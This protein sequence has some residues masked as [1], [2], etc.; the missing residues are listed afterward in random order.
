MGV[1]VTVGVG[2]GVRVG[3]GV[4]VGVAVGLG[5]GVSVGV[6]SASVG[7]GL[8]AVGT[9]NPPEPPIAA[10]V[11]PVVP[12]TTTDGVG[13]RAPSPMLAGDATAGTSGWAEEATVAGGGVETAVVGCGPIGTPARK[14]PNANNN[15]ANPYPVNNRACN[16]SRVL[17]NRSRNN[18][19]GDCARYAN[20]IAI[21]APRVLNPMPHK[22]QIGNPPIPPNY[23]AKR[24]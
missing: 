4:P 14:K 8:A 10:P 9:T 3:V 11:L 21:R 6:P 17:Y 12:V 18:I 24:P 2:D 7:K 13:V 15:K 22:V 1:G 19:P 20:P 16:A 5:R 23:N